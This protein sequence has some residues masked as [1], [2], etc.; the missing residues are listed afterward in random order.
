[1]EPPSATGR[2]WTTMDKTF[3]SAGF[4]AATIVSI[5]VAASPTAAAADLVGPGCGAYAALHTAGP[6]SM[7]GMSQDPV[8]TAAEN[9]PDLTMFAAAFSA[10]LNPQVYFVD[11]L[12][13]GQYTVFAP[14]DTAFHKLPGSMIDDLE[15]NSLVLDDIL[16]YHVVPGRL[17]SDEVIGTHKT[18]QGRT[19]NVTGQGSGLRVNNAG[20]FCG[21]VPTLNATVYM[22]DTVLMPAS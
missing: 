14:T 12:N 5:A 22:I 3:A 17:N 11:I 1:M 4:A 2:E 9:N 18:L 19:V 16:A 8:A 21:G 13:N 7:E 6:A 20:L 15:T 10:Q